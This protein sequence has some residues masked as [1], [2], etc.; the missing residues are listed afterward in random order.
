MGR[1]KRFEPYDGGEIIDGD[2]LVA[3]NNLAPLLARNRTIL[4][5]RHDVANDQNGPRG[6]NSLDGS[7]HGYYE[8]AP[9]PA[10]HTGWR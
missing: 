1:I 4:K 8:A 2:D 5:L 3:A 7:S 10:T 6:R 9:Q